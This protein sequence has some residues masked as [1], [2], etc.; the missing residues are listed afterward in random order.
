MTK[1]NRWVFAA[2]AMAGAVVAI[3][4]GL[5]SI[6]SVQAAAITP[7]SVNPWQHIVDCWG[8]MVG[9]DPAHATYCS[10]GQPG[11]NTTLVTPVPGGG[12]GVPLVTC[13]ASLSRRAFTT[14]QVASLD[15]AINA[16]SALSKAQEV[17]FASCGPSCFPCTSERDGVP[18]DILRVASLDEEIDLP[19]PAASAHTLLVACCPAGN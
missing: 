17:V 14:Y 15:D 16:P 9:G 6:A 2:R 7:D 1:R 19:P 10:P 12:G 8:A 11:S 4:M 3:A 5:S 18:T 13:P